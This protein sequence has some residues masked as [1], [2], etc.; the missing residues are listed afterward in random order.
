[1]LISQHYSLGGYG[2]T[3]L[4]L[5]VTAVPITKPGMQESD[6]VG[7]ARRVSESW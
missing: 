4:A 7:N 5:N 6:G 3:V 2:K 1:M